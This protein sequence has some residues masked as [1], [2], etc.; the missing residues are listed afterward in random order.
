MP[1][2]NTDVQQTNTA[3]DLVTDPVCGMNKPKK[4]MKFVST[5]LGKNYYFCSQKDQEIFDAHP[6]YWIPPE[7][8]EKARSKL[9]VT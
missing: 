6:D 8:R 2:D 9:T 4:E 7:E 1:N 3:E 5:F